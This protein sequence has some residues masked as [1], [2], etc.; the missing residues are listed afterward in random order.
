MRLGISSFTYHYA[1]TRPADPR[2]ALGPLDLLARAAAFGVK[3]VQFADNM[4]LGGLSVAELDDLKSAA[5]DAGVR[6]EVG[7]RGFHRE[8]IRRYIRIAA[9][10]GS[11]VLRIVT[12]SDG[13]EPSRD[14]MVGAL[15]GLAPELR[16]AGV[17]LA[18]ENHDR[19][20]SA[21][22]LEIMQAVDSPNVGICLDTV[23]SLVA[24]E[25]PYTVADTLADFTVNLHIK[26]VRA[27]RDPTGL[28]VVIGGA[29]AGQGQVDIPWVIQRVGAAGRDPNAIL[30]QW[31][32]LLDDPGQT[33]AQEEDWARQS[34]AYLRTLIPD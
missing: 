28:G 19:F 34:V 13:H 33:V 31:T 10:L 29:P 25:D 24:L 21:E 14:E 22:L 2:Q 4:P 1:I 8:A 18:V 32:P 3:V 30:E 15:R 9:D 12:D 26:D 23:N 11:P 17:A 5:R 6:I 7:M 20:R 27:R 16:G